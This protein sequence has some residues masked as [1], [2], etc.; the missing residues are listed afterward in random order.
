MKSY[1]VIDLYGKKAYIRGYA[2]FMRATFGATIA[3]SFKHAIGM[4]AEAEHRRGMRGTVA[5]M[6]PE[7]LAAIENREKVWKNYYA[8]LP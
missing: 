4:S 3:G 2:A 7:L 6:R 1:E 5:E 8:R